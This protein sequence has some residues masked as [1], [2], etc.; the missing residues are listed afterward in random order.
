MYSPRRSRLQS[1]GFRLLLTSVLLSSAVLYTIYTTAGNGLL[2]TADAPLRSWQL[3]A[4]AQCQAIQ[5]LPGPGPDFHGRQQSDRFVEGTNPVLIKNARIWTGAHNGT[6]ILKNTDI[7]L[8]QG[9]IQRVGHLGAGVEL[10]AFLAPAYRDKLVKIDAKGAWVT[11]GI[12]DVHSHAGVGSA[13]ELSGA[14][15]GNSDNGNIQPWLRSVDG[16]NTHD[17]AYQLGIAGGVTT[18]LVLPGSADA[19][20]ALFTLASLK[21]GLTPLNL[22]AARHS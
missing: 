16:I 14:N 2:N 7:L 13:P 9:L 10:E 6:E 4:I 18:A 19:I 15:D 11:P 8:H 22:K 17:D 20:G 1:T 21:N 5:T 12:V 3:E